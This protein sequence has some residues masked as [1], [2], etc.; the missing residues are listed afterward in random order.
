MV[1][2]HFHLVTGKGKSLVTIVGGISWRFALGFGIDRYS[3]NL[4][5]GPLWLGIEW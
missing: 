2:G 3:F 1:S 5:I 4:D